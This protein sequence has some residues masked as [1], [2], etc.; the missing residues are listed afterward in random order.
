MTASAATVS[1][2]AGAR[3]GREPVPLLDV[4][5]T[6]LTLYFFAAASRPNLRMVRS[7]RVLTRIL[8]VRWPSSHQNFF[9]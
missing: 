9:V 8:T 7:A 4:Y 1:T 5:F 2:A 6:R 3:S